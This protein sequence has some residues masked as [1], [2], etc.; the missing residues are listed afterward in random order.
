MA[1]VNIPGV[2]YVS[3]PDK[4]SDEQILAQARAIQEKAQQPLFDSRDL[5][6]SEIIKGGFSRGL[7]GLKGTVF[8]LIPALGA[9]LFGNDKYAKEQ[10]KEFSDRMTAEEVVN[11][12]AYKSYKDLKGR[13]I[14][15]A[16]DYAAETFGELGPDIASFMLGTGAGTVVGKKVAAKGLEKIAAE[17]A[18]K[19]AAKKGLTKEA[20]TAYAERL[21]NRAKDGII[22][23]QAAEQGAKVGLDTGLWGT[24]LG[25]NVPDV[26]NSIYQ[27]TGE[28]RPGLALTIGP[29]VAAL[30]TYLPGKMLKQL[31]PTGKER[32]AAEMLQKSTIVPTTWKK[33]FAGEVLKTATGEGITE[34]A[35]QVLQI[36]GSQI[37]GDKDPFFS[38]KNI[39]DIINSS[40]KG[41]IGGG[42]Y[43][44]P[45][46]AL[47]AKRIKDERN[48]QIA[49]R[50][51]QQTTTQQTA[52][53]D[54]SAA[55]QLTPAEA[56]AQRREEKQLTARQQLT[57]DLFG[58]PPSAAQTFPIAS[59]NTPEGIRLAERLARRGPPPPLTPEPRRG[60]Q[61]LDLGTEPIQGEL[62][63][64]EEAPT[65]APTAPA[66]FKTVLDAP[67]L[68]RTGLKPQSGFFKQLLNKD[69]A[70]PED[71]AAVRDVLVQVRTN[72]NLSETTKKAIEAIAMNAFGALAKQQEMFGPR[73]GVLKGADV[74]KSSTKPVSE[75]AGTSVSNIGEPESTTGETT[76][77][78]EQLE[79]TGVAS[80]VAP[81]IES[82]RR[83]EAQSDTLNE[84][85]PLPDEK[86]LAARAQTTVPQTV[87]TPV[88]TKTT[89]AVT[90]TPTEVS[91]MGQIAT[92]LSKIEQPAQEKTT[93]TKKQTKKTKERE[94]YKKAV[95]GREDAFNF[96]YAKRWM[97]SGKGLKEIINAALGNDANPLPTNAVTALQNGDVIGALLE[98]AKVGNGFVSRMAVRFAAAGVSPNIVIQNNLRNDIGKP[99]PGFYD[100]TNNTVYLDALTG[101]NDH[102]LLHE[103]GHAAMSHVLDNPSHPLTR[104]LQQIF[105]KV[106]DSLDTA[107]GA[108]DIHEFASEAY[109]NKRFADVLR[110]IYPDG[111]AHSAWDRFSRAVMNFFRR[112]VGLESRP[113]ESAYDEVD[114]VLSGIVSP[115]PGFRDAGILFAQA[116]NKSPQVF[117]FTDRMINA[118]PLL[119]ESQKDALSGGIATGSEVTKSAL[120]S[121]LPM[122]ALGEITDKVFPGLG[123]RFNTLINLRSGE[124]GKFNKQIDAVLSE[125]KHAIKTKP[126]QRESF[127][128][129]VMDSTLSGVDP[130]KPRSDYAK[131]TDESGNKLDVE[132]DR[133]NTKYKKL[134]KV[135]QDLYV[136]MRNAY[137]AMYKQIKEAI[138]A[139]IDETD[140]DGD[141]KEKIK[142]EIMSRLAEQGMIE[143]YFA[144][145]R[146]GNLWL[147]SDY[148]DKNGQKQFTVEAFKSPRERARREAE[149]KALDPNSRVDVYSNISQV[150]F[151]NAPSGSFVNSVL[152]IMETNGV[153]KQAIDETMRLFISTLPETA[154]A[155]A[156]QKRK[157]RAGAKTDSIGV[158]ETKMRSTAHQ[159][160][161][162]LYNPKLTK[163]VDD[164]A[165]ISKQIGESGKDNQL[166]VQYVDEFRK[167]LDYVRNPTKKDVG[168]ILTSGAFFYTLGFNISSAIVNMANVPM[169]VLPYLNGKYAGGNVSGAI[170]NAS[171]VFLNSGTK[172]Q[173]PVLGADGRTTTMN[174][175]PSI[176]NYAPDSAMGKKYATLIRIADE[177][178]QLNRS[179][180]Y[181]IINGDTRTGPLAK[182][183]AMAGWA[184]HHGE[185]MNREV[186]MIASYDLEL[187]KLNKQGITGEAA[188]I[189]A[190]N[191][192]I[193]TAELT[194]GGTSAASAP[195]IAHGTLGKI[196][197]MYKRYGVSMYYMLFKTAKEALKGEDAATRK[198]AWQQL[199]GIFGMSAL[200]AG[201]QGVPLYGLASMVYSMFCDD[202]D[203]DLDTVT[204]KYMGEFMYKGPIEYFTNLSIA[205]RISLS[206]LVVRDTKGGTSAGTFSQQLFTAIG[207][208]VVG[209]G[210][211]IQ[212]GYSKMAEGHF[213]R[214]LEDVLPSF[215]ANPL[216]ALRYATEGT[217]TLRGDPITGDVSAWNVGAQAFGFAPADYTRQ[218]EENTRL[219]G[220]DKYTAQKATKLKQMWNLARTVGD[221]DDMLDAREK[222][223]ELGTKHPGLGLNAGTITE[224]LENSRRQYNQATKEMAHGVRYSK[225]MLSELKSRSTEYDQ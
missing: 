192:A 50:A 40:L 73:G 14:G 107:Y 89:S 196:L 120:F 145:S 114:R 100:P 177:Q 214:G 131:K 209:V 128:D 39:D 4:L 191:N 43:G 146:E 216:K 150:N 81:A 178:G 74:G 130:T 159:V 24:S 167:H 163:V 126:A 117:S 26:F 7:E 210:D 155:K 148:V 76:G 116:A 122:H 45:G 143:P 9:S 70:N 61:E 34:G 113:L 170:G 182:I 125:A 30:D 205:S 162:M 183:N 174:V 35:Q 176:S 98:L 154:F 96:D 21:L 86:T 79:P 180:L 158:F 204:R 119:S 164:M 121:I 11:P 48:N 179:Q 224:I 8:D 124:E 3:F 217:Q 153:P 168:S 166:E 63:S 185:R 53:P 211:R 137:G 129:V 92:A 41:F 69:M 36:L 55:T 20:E 188:E 23:K 207:G 12:A 141:T 189:Q 198:A 57:G 27:D 149:I 95:A 106:K 187:A 33:A 87:E 99:V 173:M 156:F 19:V 127:D 190:A 161:N 175:M 42:T 133:V 2:G 110:S 218:I 83:E 123:S 75:P 221:A 1:R 85:T 206:D 47:E 151:R 52:S 223:V 144:L 97:E 139:R 67:A 157:G 102:V 49:L 51:A 213:M 68:Q 94:E 64:Q 18:A 101:L 37:A 215:V 16:F 195:R 208:P 10:L 56:A 202:D 25:T 194:N 212:R 77:G 78:A 225:K 115:A 5:P 82:A 138:Q 71:Q 160:T 58:M 90:P 152:K 103:V 172:T 32:I 108:Q 118:V 38:Q 186:T 84:T 181:E 17:E 134:D 28:L 80:A 60:Q 59:E 197:F 142:S 65:P 200:M 201:A 184:F 219:K 135:W 220:I 66:E 93:E 132:W 171:K 6:T 112:M 31:G 104:Q 46:G 199:G 111:T 22:G 91:T 193:Y 109:G 105:D 136:T 72:P 222:L 62:F 203:D 169:I 44:L 13:G 165:E 147:A 88:A 29:L 140:L 15:G 54:I